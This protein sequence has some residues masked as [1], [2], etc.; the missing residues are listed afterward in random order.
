[1]RRHEYI[2]ACAAVKNIMEGSNS[3]DREENFIDSRENKNPMEG[4]VKDYVFSK[5]KEK[6]ISLSALAREEGRG[7]VFGNRSV[8]NESKLCNCKKSLEEDLLPKKPEEISRYWKNIKKEYCENFALA[9]TEGAENNLPRSKR[10]TKNR[11]VF[12][13]EKGNMFSAAFQKAEK[14]F[15]ELEK[16]I[17]REITINRVLNA[18]SGLNLKAEIASSDLD[19]KNKIDVIV[20]SIEADGMDKIIIAVQVKGGR[21]NENGKVA[22]E[23]FADNKDSKKK[24]FFDGCEKFEKKL[25]TKVSDARVIKIWINVSDDDITGEGAG[26]KDELKVDIEYELKKILAEYR[27]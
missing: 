25:K 12:D 17:M 7:I 6:K 19:I 2:K 24:E 18:I 27:S 21:G 23:V 26:Y 1:M 13:E 16:G 15:D 20:Y 22:E 5:E 8:N 10:K 11:T 9:L 14:S 3:M 4:L